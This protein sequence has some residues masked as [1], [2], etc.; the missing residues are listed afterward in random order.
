MCVYIY[1]CICLYYWVSTCAASWQLC[2]SP[3]YQARRAAP[4]L[5]SSMCSY[6]KQEQVTLRLNTHTHTQPYRVGAVTS[7]ETC[8]LLKTFTER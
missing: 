8:T 3:E 4:G 2:M 7:L 5:A 1:T 6:T